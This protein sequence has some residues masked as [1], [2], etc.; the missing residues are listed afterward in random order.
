MYFAALNFFVCAING[1]SYIFFLK[2]NQE[3]GSG[4]EPMF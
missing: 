3:V 4:M 2:A 1:H